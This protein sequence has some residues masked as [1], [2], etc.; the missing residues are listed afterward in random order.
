[1]Q[2]LTNGSDLGQAICLCHD[3]FHL[4]K[5]RLHCLKAFILHS[6]LQA[7]RG[8]RKGAEGLK[9]VFPVS[10]RLEST[11]ESIAAACWPKATASEAPTW[12]AFPSSTWASLSCLEMAIQPFLPSSFRNPVA[13]GSARKGK[14]GAFPLS[15]WPKNLVQV[16]RGG[17]SAIWN[18]E[19]SK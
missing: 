13:F 17:I 8:L 11:F 3:T 4:E 18:S 15:P 16:H 6:S 12:G 19:R 2:S 1:M 5:A 9:G 14:E 7:P 10:I